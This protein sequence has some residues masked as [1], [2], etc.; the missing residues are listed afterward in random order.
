MKSSEKQ[1]PVVD[2]EGKIQQGKAITTVAEGAVDASIIDAAQLQD[3]AEGVDD[4][5]QQQDKTEGVDD[6]DQQQG[7]TEGVDDQDQQQG[8]TEGVDDQDQQQDK[9]GDEDQQQAPKGPQIP[10]TAEAKDGIAATKSPP[11]SME[12]S[13]ETIE[14]KTDTAPAHPL[15]SEHAAHVETVQAKQLCS[16]VMM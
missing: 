13:E 3:K 11:D 15:E 1:G 2:E 6:H 12:A 7:K 14:Q 8:K 4:H 16:C 9:T 5:D 10:Q